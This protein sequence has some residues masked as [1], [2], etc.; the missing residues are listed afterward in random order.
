MKVSDGRVIYSATNEFPGLVAY[1]GDL[2]P[3]PLP[4]LLPK[5]GTSSGTMRKAKGGR[6]WGDG[7]G[8]EASGGREMWRR[9]C[10]C[11]VEALG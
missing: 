1:S 3:W 5:A 7:K 8:W 2:L 6:K 9:T 4:T 10:L 11:E